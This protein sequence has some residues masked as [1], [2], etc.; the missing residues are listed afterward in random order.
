MIHGSSLTGSS[1]ILAILHVWQF[2]HR[3]SHIL[4]GGNI[5]LVSLLSLVNGQSGHR[6]LSG[7]MTLI[8]IK[9]NF[10]LPCLELGCQAHLCFL[11][12]LPIEFCFWRFQSSR[13]CREKINWCVNNDGQHSLQ[14]YLSQNLLLVRHNNGCSSAVQMPLQVAIEASQ[15]KAYCTL[16]QNTVDSIKI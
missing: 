5:F 8:F 7:S 9:D 4:S 3:P 6:G 13:V 15:H 2:L 14:K 1:W 11:P 10:Y 12:R 16:Y